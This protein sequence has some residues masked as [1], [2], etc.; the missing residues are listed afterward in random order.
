MVAI[1]YQLRGS[2]GETIQ[3]DTDNF[4]LNPNII[5][6]GVAP[7]EVRV[8]PSAGI[9]GVFRHSRRSVRELD[10]PVTVVGA[11]RADVQSKLRRL[12]RITQDRR[13]PMRFRATYPNGQQLFLDL[14]YV[15]GAEGQWGGGAGGLTWMRLVMQCVAPQPFWESLQKQSFQLAGGGTG[16]GLLPQLTKLRVSSSQALGDVTISSDADVEV[17]PVWNVT[18]PVDDFTVTNGVDSF[19]ITGTI[20]GSTTVTIDTENKTVVDQDGN[21][22]YDR[23]GPAPKL[24]PFQPGETTL[25]ITGAGADASTLVFAE[26][27]L[28]FE[29]VH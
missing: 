7:T 13:G 3:F 14:H 19:T 25:E 20:D 17:F 22:L 4:V 2:N 6:L 26:Y 21:N 9:G 1:Q 12:A 11:N 29:V 23:L 5:G 28:R 24:F 27:A 16:R 15:G 18:G 8:D 10:L